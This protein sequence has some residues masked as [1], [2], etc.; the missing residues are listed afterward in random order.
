[1]KAEIYVP[2]VAESLADLKVSFELLEPARRK[3]IQTGLMLIIRPAGLSAEKIQLQLDN[4]DYFLGKPIPDRPM[5]FG[6]HPNMPLSGSE[7]LNFLTNPNWSEEYVRR[8]IEMMAKLPSELTPASGKAIS[9]HLNTLVALEA[10]AANEPH[11]EKAFEG[12]LERIKGL[13]AFG[14]D[15]GVRIAIETT[16][17]PEFGDTPRNDRSLLNNSG[18]G[19]WPDLINP[20]PLLFWRGEIEKLREAGANLTIDICHSYIALRTILEIEKYTSKKQESFLARYGLYAS[21][22][23]H[24]R[25]AMEFASLVLEHTKPG[26]IW[27]VNDARGFYKSPE[28]FGEESFFEEGVQLFEG[29]IPENDLMILIRE[30]LR[31]R[32]KFV[33]EV[34]ETDF[35]NRPNTKMSL[36]R[37][38][39]LFEATEDDLAITR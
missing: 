16:P 32:I 30:G 14:A 19:Y 31:K 7:R 29:D 13:V 4:L 3:C 28:L 10:W 37:V 25:E 38:L 18:G 11:W 33:L 36:E 6:M 17:I 22:L 35:T 9:L 20:W 8:G 26:D 2:A 24:A 23:E 12:V 39:G 5:V 34:H 21:D 27:H 15:H 1:M